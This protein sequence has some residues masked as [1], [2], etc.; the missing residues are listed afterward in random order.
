MMGMRGRVVTSKSMTMVPRKEK[1]RRRMFGL[2][3]DF[4]QDNHIGRNMEKWWCRR[5][6]QSEQGESARSS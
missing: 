5:A 6:L 1:T 3:G 4:Y 2:C